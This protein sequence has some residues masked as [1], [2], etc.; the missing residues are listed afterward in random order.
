MSGE[1]RA[2][3]KVLTLAENMYL[4][5]AYEHG[6]Q[7]LIQ[8]I[9]QGREDNK[10]VQV[11]EQNAEVGVDQ[12]GEVL[13]NSVEPIA[14]YSRR[15][16]R[17]YLKYEKIGYDNVEYLRKE[18]KR[19][20]NGV[21]GIANDI[22]LSIENDIY[23]CDCRNEDGDI[24]LGVYRKATVEDKKI[25][26]QNLEDINE[27]AISKG[28]VCDEVS[29]NLRRSSNERSGSSIGRQIQEEL[30]VDNG[31]SQ[32]IKERVSREDGNRGNR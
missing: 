18:V 30:S 7:N 4:R 6:R 25:R 1:Q 20:F 9:E 22:G 10:K 26:Y 13:Y 28:Y 23:Y 31:Q 5:S 19:L 32:D 17:S 2:E 14:Q 3:Y 21:N 12:K 8:I 24:Y 27:R 11:D 29:K 15:K 16:T